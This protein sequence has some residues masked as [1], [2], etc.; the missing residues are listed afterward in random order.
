V[1][2]EDIMTYIESCGIMGDRRE[3]VGGKGTDQSI[4]TSGIQ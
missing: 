2:I 3:G 4:V 1:L